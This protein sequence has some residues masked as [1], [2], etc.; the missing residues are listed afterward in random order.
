MA[1]S[2]EEQTKPSQVLED[3][4]GGPSEVQKPPP[5]PAW[6][7][8]FCDMMMLLLAF[9][10]LLFTFSSLESSKYEVIAKSVR[11][12][13]GGNVLVDGEIIRTG[14]SPDDDFTEL[15]SQEVMKPY[16]IEFL[17]TKGI[18][19]TLEINRSSDGDKG[20]ITRSLKETKLNL[21][22]EVLWVNESIKVSLDGQAIFKEGEFEIFKIDKI[23]FNKLISL[24]RGNDW[25]VYLEGYSSKG[26]ISPQGLSTRELSAMR[27][28]ALIKELTK[29]GIS[30]SRLVSVAY[31]D[32][33]AS[34]EGDGK[35]DR[36]VTFS[37]RKKKLFNE[38]VIDD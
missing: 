4:E 8:T 9:F 19:N 30:P 34:L 17:T 3:D 21:E 26:E 35:S 10:I 14:K 31:G 37:L 6:M 32:S 1:D 29:R 16:P 28:S 33:E 13:F 2:A 7:A 12:A 18:F 36:K 22:S 15:E 5:V 38:G 25:I 20:A 11:S 23:F 24:L 27:T